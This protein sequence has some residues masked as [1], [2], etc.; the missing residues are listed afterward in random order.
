MNVLHA[1][2]ESEVSATSFRLPCIKGK[3]G[4]KKEKIYELSN[5]VAT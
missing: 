2:R 1:D 4:D 5:F 3:E